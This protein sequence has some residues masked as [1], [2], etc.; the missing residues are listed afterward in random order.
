MKHTI[1]G[2]NNLKSNTKNNTDPDAD[3]NVFRCPECSHE[4]IITDKHRG[5]CICSNCGI[6]LEEHMIDLGAE[7]RAYNSAE[8]EERCRVGSLP[9]LTA[10]TTELM[11][12]IG[13]ENRDF[14]GNK[15]SAS[16]RTQIYRLRKWQIRSRFQ[17]SS[18]KKL[19]LAMNEL[20]RLTSQLG[21]PQSVKETAAVIYRKIIIYRLV[22]GRS[23][24][25]IVAA[26]V[27]AAVRIRRVPRTLDEIANQAGISKKELGKIYRLLVRKLMLSV[28]LASPVDYLVRFGTELGLSASCQRDAAEILTSAKEQGLTGG[29]D[30]I[31]L[32]AAAIYLSGILKEERRTQKMVAAVTHVTEVTV[33]NRYKDLICKLHIKIPM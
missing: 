29:K 12:L 5:E 23:I 30:P 6:I 3:L 19:T 25:V 24:E 28:P 31:G 2:Q 10:T 26:T 32:A 14:F 16:R 33:R 7:W 21:M 4:E 8:Y 17:N 18:D 9:I 20:N 1:E 27:Y 11:T 13:K 22:K 15:L